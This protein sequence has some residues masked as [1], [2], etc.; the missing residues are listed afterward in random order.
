MTRPGGRGIATIFRASTP[1]PFD[2]DVVDSIQD[3][4]PIPA[5][6][7]LPIRRLPAPSPIEFLD[8]TSSVSGQISEPS[9]SILEDLFFSDD[10][11]AHTYS[12]EGPPFR[13]RP[14]P[15]LPG[16][17][18]MESDSLFGGPT[19]VNPSNRS[20]PGQTSSEAFPV[21]PVSTLDSDSSED[22]LIEDDVDF[23]TLPDI[24]RDVIE[25]TYIEDQ[26][27]EEIE[28]Q[29]DDDDDEIETAG[30]SQ[31]ENQVVEQ[32]AWYIPGLEIRRLYG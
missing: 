5:R 19:L 2:S 25:D 4:T 28:L 17:R 18:L 23:P 8:S 24:F 22:E 6:H 13:N 29:I 31:P 7:L 14:S 26:E 21:S 32:P 3:P 30:V 12:N 11:L 27:E 1:D 16:T 20:I 15:S 10:S 9:R